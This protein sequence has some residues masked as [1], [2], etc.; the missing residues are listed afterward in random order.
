VR[1]RLREVVLGLAEQIGQVELV[2]VC[3]LFAHAAEDDGQRQSEFFFLFVVNE[4]IR[5]SAHHGTSTSGTAGRVSSRSRH[6][7]GALGKKKKK[8]RGGGR[9]EK[10]V[11]PMRHNA[12]LC[13]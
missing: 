4:G 12:L 1:E 3:A 13:I 7:L 9:K 11:D 5:K 10:P 8:K 2:G 6:V